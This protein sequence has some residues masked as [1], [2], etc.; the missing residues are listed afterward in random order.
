MTCCSKLA[1][2]HVSDDD[3]D[4]GY[5][6]IPLLTGSVAEFYIEPM[7]SCV[8]DVDVMGHRSDMLAIPAGYTP[9]TQ[10]PGE[11]GSRVYVLEIVNSEFPGY[12]YLV[13]SYFQ[14]E[15]VDDD[16][17]K[18]TLCQRKIATHNRTSTGD[19]MMH[20]PALFHEQ[21][22]PSLTLTQTGKASIAESSQFLDIVLCV[23]CL[24]WPPQAADWPTRHRNYGWPDSATVDRVVHNG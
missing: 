1:A 11:F 7:L 20:G 3:I 2:K 5:D 24:I 21:S 17:Y 19:D 9:P 10:L 23:R 16:K 6:Y 12:V 15:C 4:L 13:N 8:N 22:I 18:V 14:T